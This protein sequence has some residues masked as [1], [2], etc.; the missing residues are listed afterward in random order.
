MELVY[1][2]CI[3]GFGQACVSFQGV[4][5]GVQV[6]IHQ[7]SDSRDFSNCLNDK[8]R[9]V[10]GLSAPFRTCL[11]EDLASAIATRVLNA[12]TVAASRLSSGRTVRILVPKTPPESAH[13][14]PRDLAE[15]RRRAQSTGAIVRPCLVDTLTDSD[16]LYDYQLKGTQWLKNRRTAILADDMGL[17]KTV[18][19]ISALRMLFRERPLNSALIVCPKQLMS[20]WENELSQWAPELSCCRLTPPARWRTEAWT[21]IFNHVH[22]IV[23]NYESVAPVL[24]MD[25]A[26]DFSI[27]VLDE[28]HRVRNSSAQVTSD[29]RNLT[30][31]RT[32]ALTGTPLERAPSDLWTILSV[33][34]PGR[35]N[36]AL[37]PPSDEALRARARPFVLRRLKIDSLPGLPTEVTK[38]ELIELLAQ[39]QTSYDRALDRFATTPDQQMLAE[40]NKLRAICDLDEESGQSAK[41]DRI[42]EVLLNIVASEEKA[43]VFSHALAPLDRLA[44]LLD[45]E[46]LH[47]LHLRGEQSS[48]E[49]D[50]ALT[51]FRKEAT[52][53]I[54]LASTRVGGEGLNLVEANHVVF[55]N[56]WW[57]PSANNQAKDRVSRIGQTRMVVVHSFTCRDTVEEVLDDIIKEKGRLSE[58]IVDALA[59]K[60]G[61]ESF[62]QEAAKSFRESLV[63]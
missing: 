4:E 5:N 3:K 2:I 35:F 9:D 57:N 59:D 1:N 53:H 34:Q 62:L 31:E 20:N 14:S 29:L 32:W 46:G 19:T 12:D 16:K 36:P 54:L 26:F 17:G 28:A 47:Y 33:I 7:H 22:V 23:T 49:R 50:L 37:M 21:R 10:R 63:L 27:L 42:V 40:F 39:Q 8:H 11:D 58:A 55:V 44:T 48:E 60:G 25:R 24:R 38:H 61:P 15:L 6:K 18:Q 56:R 30:R 41:L 52:I 43:V 13:G 45:R 51:R